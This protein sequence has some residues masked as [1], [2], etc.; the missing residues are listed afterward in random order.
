MV[1][2]GTVCAYPKFTPVPFQEDELWNGYPE[3]TNA[4]Y[5][6]AKRAI[7]VGMGATARQT[8]IKMLPPAMPSTPLIVAVR[9]TATA[10][11]ARVIWVWELYVFVHLGTAFLIAGVIGTPGCEMRAFHDLY[12]RLTGVPTKEHCCLAS[13]WRGTR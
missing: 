8:T 1:V 7:A 4:P 3:E 12:S 9:A 5:G 6:V 2:V 13:A 11:L 10:L